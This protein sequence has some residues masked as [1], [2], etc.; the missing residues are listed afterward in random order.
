MT[1]T[2]VLERDISAEAGVGSAALHEEEEGEEVEG[3]STSDM[4]DGCV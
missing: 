1:S 3:S 2:V 4:T